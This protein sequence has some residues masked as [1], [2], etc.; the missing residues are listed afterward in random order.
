MDISK[1]YDAILLDILNPIMDKVED[2]L[3]APVEMLADI[4]PNLS[5][6]FAN[7]GLL[8]V[9]D[10]LLTPVSALLDAIKPIIDI[11]A[12]LKVLGV[13]INSLLAK[14]G[15]KTNVT[16]NVYDLKATLLPLIGAEN[17]VSLLNGILSTVKIGGSTLGIELPAIDWLQLASHGEIEKIPSQVATIGER[18]VVKADQDETLIAVLRFIINTVNYKNNYNAIV[19]LVGGLLGGA[20]DSVSGMVGQ[21]L[22]MLQGDAD[23]V[24]ENLVELLQS[25]AG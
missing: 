2:L 8:Q 1:Q 11:N 24:I 21:V 20:G 9:L 3:N 23:T 17:V 6:F 5:L 7:N 19:G 22:G 18:I 13:N 16:V 4:L 25:L 12:L 10:N 14:V 15:V